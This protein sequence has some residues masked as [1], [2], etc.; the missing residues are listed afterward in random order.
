MPASSPGMQLGLRDENYIGMM[1][2][3]SGIVI[4]YMA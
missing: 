3:A 2:V 4:D 1:M